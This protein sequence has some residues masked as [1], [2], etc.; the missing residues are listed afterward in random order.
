MLDASLANGGLTTLAAIP[1]R[2]GMTF[3]E[4]AVFFNRTM[5]IGA[6]LTVVP[7]KNWNRS[8]LWDETGMPWT[9]PSPALVDSKQAIYYA[10]FGALEAVDLAVGR[11]KDNS[12]AFTVF[13][14]PWITEADQKALV[15]KLN[16]IEGLSVSA[17]TWTPDRATYMG[18]LCRGFKIDLKSM[19]LPAF[20][21]LVD[22]VK[23]M[24]QVLGSRFNT[25]EMLSMIGGKWVLQ[26]I[27]RN[28][29]TASI[30]EKGQADYSK[31]MQDRAQA[32]LY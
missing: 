22:T 25:A 27:D 9:P 19:S 28:E 3:G 6:D 16:A 26:A 2:H 11:G 31:F 21:T 14:A 30:V 8:M 32:L 29:S 17:Y 23:A 12:L 4:L 15:T 1:T 7:M 10:I 20:K 24:K 13:G 18:K 5:K